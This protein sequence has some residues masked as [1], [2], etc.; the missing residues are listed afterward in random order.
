[1]DAW[2]GRQMHSHS[3]RVPEPF[4]GEVVVVVGCGE[5]GKDIAM[6]IRGVAKEVYLV[7]KS[8]EEV[9]PGL[10]K[11]LSKHRDSLH[12][13]L[14]VERLCEDGSVVFGDGSGVVADTVIYCTGYRYSFPFL[15]TGGAV[16]I[17]NN[18]VGP[19]FEH[20]FPP[21]LAPSLSFVGINRKI[22]APRFFETQ[23]KWVAQVLSGK[24]TLPM[25]EEMLRSVEEFYHARKIAGVPRKYTHEIGWLEP[26]VTNK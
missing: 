18:R 19:L 17:D 13:R 15:D 20:V 5:S 24:R 23:A 11:V 21:S 14:Q 16:T 6:E 8:M 3:Y 9:T 12:L 26:T 25:E 2:S 10:S 7:A 1:M 4:G 22:F